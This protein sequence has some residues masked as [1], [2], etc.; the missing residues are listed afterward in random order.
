MPARK[1]PERVRG[2]DLFRSLAHPK[3]LAFVGAS[4]AVTAFVFGCGIRDGEFELPV[5][6]NEQDHSFGRCVGQCSPDYGARPI[7]IEECAR[8][9]MG[10]EFFPVPVWDWEVA[11]V[12]L[13]GDIQAYT[14]QDGTTEFLSTST[15]TCSVEEAAALGEN[16]TCQA[17]YNPL[18]APVDRCGSTQA[19][20]VRGG[21]FREWG[22][23]FGKR[24]D[25][26]ANLAAA[27]MGGSCPPVPPQEPDPSLPAVCPEFDPYVANAP[28][29]FI[30]ASGA[31]YQFAEIESLYY[32]MMVDLREWEGISFWARR[33]PDSQPGFRIA[34]GDRNLDDDVSMLTTAGGLTNPRCRRA[35]ECGCR[36]HR[37]CTPGPQ[38]GFFCWD[39]ALDVNVEAQ[40]H[41]WNHELPRCGAT[42]CDYRYAAYERVPDWPFITPEHGDNF[43][44]AATA[45]CNSFTFKNDITRDQCFDPNGLP[46]PEGPERCGDPWFSPVRLSEDWQFFRVPFTELRQ[47][48]YGKEF[49]VIDLSAITM[50]RF[51]WT[52]GWVDYW[53][54]DVR[55]Y[56]R[57][58]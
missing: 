19:L 15:P 45:S 14:Y 17:N 36:N 24:L 49:P 31:T 58:R 51:T 32:L 8:V 2:V 42:Q 1:P 43:A 18:P 13:T 38:G 11:N 22:G 4:F 21:P 5:P 54:D 39:P 52:V 33:G 26:V 3:T 34:L 30:P 55:F 6:W 48:G 35:K 29:V 12:A 57:Q 23:G 28:G 10:L 40:M 46:P 47:E 27:A 20:H 7:T 37:P 44:S 25:N 56:R 9:E 41:P 53:I 50:V 16:T